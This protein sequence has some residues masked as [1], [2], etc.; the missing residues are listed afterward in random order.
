M[1]NEE[2][3]H[4]S[5]TADQH[6]QGPDTPRYANPD[7]ITPGARIGH[8]HLRTADIDR[9]RAFYVDILGFDIVMEGRGVLGWA[10]DAGRRG[11]FLFLAAGGYH[12]QLGFNTWRS[13]GGPPQPEGVA[14]LQ[15]VAILY[16]TRADLADALRRLR[17]AGWPLQHAFDHGTHEALYVRDPDDNELEL[18]W[19]RPGDRW[20]RDAAGHIQMQGGPLDLDELLRIA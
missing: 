17:A 15:H 6:L 5:I 14:G 8:V 4:M 1:P 11:D 2:H 12:H 18:Y 9:V 3:H 7:P 19:D 16:P 10:A 20:P 13:A